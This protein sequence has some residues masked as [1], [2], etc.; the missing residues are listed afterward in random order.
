[1]LRVSPGA[2]A[3]AVAGTIAG[4]G[5]VSVFSKTQQEESLLKGT[6][7]K[8]RRQIG[9]FTVLLTVIAAIIMALILYTLT[10]DKLHSIAR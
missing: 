10:L 3:D 9:L 4:W 1:M 7:D 8:A 5:D 2:S 6:V